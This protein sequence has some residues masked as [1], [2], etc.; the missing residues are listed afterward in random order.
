[1][2]I[3]HNF[4]L[5]LIFWNKPNYP[6]NPYKHFYPISLSLSLPHIVF[7]FFILLL[8]HVFVNN[9]IF[10]SPTI[11]TNI[12]IYIIKSNHCHKILKFY[13]FIYLF[14][15]FFYHTFAFHFISIFFHKSHYP[16][17]PGKILVDIIHIVVTTYCFQ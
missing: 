10:V 17:N 4:L 14:T 16:I 2:F 11:T 6:M 15:S 7:N 9:L 5:F 12:V 13:L 1:M 8:F 3:I